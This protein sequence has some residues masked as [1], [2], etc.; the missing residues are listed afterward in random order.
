M[1]SAVLSSNR[2]DVMSKVEQ[3]TVKA[4]L[5]TGEWIGEPEFVG[6]VD[7]TAW[8]AMQDTDTAHYDTYEHEG[9]TRAIKVV[10]T[11]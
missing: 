4:D 10:W 3:Y 6:V 5:T 11:E 1:D 7:L 2:K 8:H 9:V